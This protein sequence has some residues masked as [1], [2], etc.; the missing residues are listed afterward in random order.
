MILSRLL[1]LLPSEAQRGGF[2]GVFG[3]FWRRWSRQKDLVVE[4]KALPGQ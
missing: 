1:R 4:D 3:N 2:L